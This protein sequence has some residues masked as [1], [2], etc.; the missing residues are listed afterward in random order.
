MTLVGPYICRIHRDTPLPHHH[1]THC[2]AEV[3]SKIIVNYL[4]ASE[5]NNVQL[6]I[7]STSRIQ[8]IA[9]SF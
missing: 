2:G 3:I 6:L 9:V 1:L 7:L 8:H 5:P 4:F